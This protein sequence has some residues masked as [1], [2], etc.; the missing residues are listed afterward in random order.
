MKSARWGMVALLVGGCGLATPSIEP[1]ESE[2]PVEVRTWIEGQ[3][4]RGVATLVVQVRAA[5]G[6][7]AA[8]PEPELPRLTVVEAGEP[9]IERVGELTV[10][11]RRYRVTGPQGSY[12]I[13]SLSTGPDA[14][15]S[16]ALWI[17]LGEPTEALDQLFDIEDPKAV[18]QL[19]RGLVVGAVCVGLVG[20]GSLGGLALAFGGLAG[21]APKELPPEPPD[22]VALR[23]WDAVRA[24]PEL[25]DQAVAVAIA[26]IL[27]VYI[28]AV[29]GFPATAWTTREILD[30]L[31]AMEHLPEGSVGRAK[32]ILRATD[33]IKFADAKAR[34]ALFDELDDALRAFVGTTRP[35]RFEGDGQEPR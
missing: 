21:R 28:E 34:E 8:H 25:D 33:F 20:L 6:V 12:E 19:D 35:Q 23:R 17:D 1:A 31:G 2:A 22:V 26:E 4:A 5:Q 15:P 24:D 10:S 13:P 32:R 14:L 3:P 30:Q 29:L 16:D 7:T 11:T 18:F 9:S 27:R